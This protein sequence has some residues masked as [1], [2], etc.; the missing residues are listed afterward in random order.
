[1]T[2]EA[3]HEG[4]GTSPSEA[5]FFACGA[6]S[7][8]REIAYRRRSAPVDAEPAPGIFWL[9]GFRSNMR[10]EKASALDRLA[11][12]M[13]CAFLRFDYSGHGESSGRFE[14]GTIGI[15]LEESLAVLRGLT[16]GPQVV[17]GSSMGAWIALLVA[18]AFAAS[19]ESD[20]LKGLVLVAPAVDFTEK[21]IWEFIPPR[22]RK[23]LDKN[24]L[25]LRPSPYAPDPDPI[26]KTLIEEGRAHLLLGGV[27]RTFCPVHILQG[28]A[29]AIV[30]WRH[31]MSLAEHLAGDPVSVTLVKDGD[32]RLSRE[33][34]LARL[35][36]AVEAMLKEA[37]TGAA[38]PVQPS[39]DFDAESAT[40]ESLD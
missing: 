8:R 35:R 16:S 6:A 1:M 29:D 21:L 33:E 36:A 30:P 9:G 24:G 40:S 10:G 17:V 26:T 22:A 12:E 18:K 32:H 25:W 2:G 31:A 15:W 4:E 37:S 11:A 14:D 39:F 20:R 27:I 13:G 7:A 19:G 23:A 3:L 38:R 34:D 28:M 5:G